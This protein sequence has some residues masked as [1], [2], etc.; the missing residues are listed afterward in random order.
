ME[1][2]ELNHFKA[3]NNPL[4]LESTGH[5]NVLLFGENG[6]GKSSI[7]S[8]LEYIFYR[9]KIESPN[10]MLPHADQ[11]AEIAAVRERYKNNQSTVP[12]EL[13][14]NG[15]DAFAVNVAPYQAFMLNRFDKVDKISL[16]DVL[17]RNFLPEDVNTFLSNNYS[18]IIDNVNSELEHSFLEPIEISIVDRTNGY[19]VIIQNKDTHLSRSQEL[20]KYFNEAIINL[21]QLLVWFSSVQL[22]EDPTKRRI[23]VLDDFITSL[24]AANRAYMMRYLL[25]TFTQEQLIILTHDYSLFNITSYLIAHIYQANEKWNRYKLYMMGDDHCLDQIRKINIQKLKSECQNTRTS[26]NAIGNKVRKCFE[27][28]LYDL[29]AELSV[30]QLEKTSDIIECI[31]SSKN[32]YFNPNSSLSDLIAEIESMLPTIAD[33]TVRK[34]FADKIDKYKIPEAALLKDTVRLLRF[35]QKISM[36]PIS[37]GTLGVPHYYRKDVEESIKLL[38]QLDRCVKSILDGRI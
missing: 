7:F 33:A 6:A 23:I 16:Y 34:T 25:K 31:G 21:V 29:A 1:R 30:G 26:Y 9:S 12:F 2:L 22:M 3:F 20:N 8:A 24:D 19:V 15:L 4:V 38:E 32:V 36:H 28:R 11:L 27:Q 13:K 14:F 10:P 5:K 35:Y 17:S 18:F 37:H